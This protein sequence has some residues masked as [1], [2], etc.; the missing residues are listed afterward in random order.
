M[1]AGPAGREGDAQSAQDDGKQNKFTFTSFFFGH[2]T[3]ISHINQGSKGI[4]ILK[5]CTLQLSFSDSF[6]SHY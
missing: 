4:S 6:T 1:L 5:T 3:Y 2:K